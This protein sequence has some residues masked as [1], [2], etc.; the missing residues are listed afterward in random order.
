MKDTIRLPYITSRLALG[1]IR[2]GLLLHTTY[3]NS[4][5]K[6]IN[7]FEPDHNF[8]APGTIS[9]HPDVCSV[10]RAMPAQPTQASYCRPN[11]GFSV[12]QKVELNLTIIC[13][14]MG[15]AVA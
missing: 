8:I 12:H 13:N 15:H 1:D 14:K 7:T 3:R 9:L 4:D 2:C 10:L 5:T 11:C 6:Q